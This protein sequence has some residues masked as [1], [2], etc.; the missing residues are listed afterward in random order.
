M[1]GRAP[2][3]TGVAGSFRVRPRRF[4]REPAGVR[5]LEADSVGSGFHAGIGPATPGA[6]DRKIARENRSGAGPG[7][8]APPGAS[9]GPVRLGQSLA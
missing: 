7:A 9:S 8:W 5:P 3:E 6:G 1:T 4:G 2:N